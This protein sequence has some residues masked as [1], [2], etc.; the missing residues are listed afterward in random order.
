MLS[1]NSKSPWE[2]S[3]KT[4]LSTEAVNTA[5]PSACKQTAKY[6]RNTES[7]VVDEEARTDF[8]GCPQMGLLSTKGW[9]DLPKVTPYI[10]D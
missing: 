10:H 7:E 9:N 6:E 4:K 8:N 2:Q 3:G 1:W 5:G